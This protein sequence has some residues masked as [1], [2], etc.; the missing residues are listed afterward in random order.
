LPGDAHPITGQLA[1]QIAAAAG[2]GLVEADGR[3][4]QMRLEV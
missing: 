4:A 3:A 1:D 2:I